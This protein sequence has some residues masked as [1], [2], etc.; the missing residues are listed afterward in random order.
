MSGSLTDMKDA[1]LIFPFAE[2]TNDQAS[3]VEASHLMVEGHTLNSRPP[4]FCRI[5]RPCKRFTCVECMSVRRK[6]FV[7]AASNHAWKHQALHFVTISWVRADQGEPWDALTKSSGQV[8][9]RFRRSGEFIFWVR[10]FGDHGTPHL[11]AVTTQRGAR[12]LEQIVHELWPGRRSTT[13][14]KTLPSMNDLIQVCGYLFDQN[15]TPI[16]LNPKR[17]SRG[18][19]ISGTRGICYG[20]PKQVDWLRLQNL[21][22]DKSRH[23]EKLDEVH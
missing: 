3:D 7:A 20:F 23:L 10:A 2:F 11:H 13:C 1:R 14:T 4:P 18:R 22:A 5:F 21:V 19:S 15:L 12:R 6:Y 8:I 17:R 16:V 9:S